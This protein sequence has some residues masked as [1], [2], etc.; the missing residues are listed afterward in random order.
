MEKEV[1]S[2][3][4]EDLKNKIPRKIY[5]DM[6]ES[7][8]HKVLDFY[9]SKS[10]FKNIDQSK[11]IEKLEE[12]HPNIDEETKQAVINRMKSMRFTLEHLYQSGSLRI[13]STDSE[14][15]Y[16]AIIDIQ[17]EQRK[18]V[19]ENRLTDSIQKV[20]EMLKEIDGNDGLD[21]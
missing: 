18:K 8:T 13:N 19:L 20:N 10:N 5:N 6:I 12:E 7:L 16:S 11:T 2:Y 9:D 14:I 17:K 1:K 15:N 21:K 3:S 4:L